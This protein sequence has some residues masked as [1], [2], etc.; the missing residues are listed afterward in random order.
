MKRPRQR[1]R[2]LRTPDGIQL[3]W[4]EAGAGR[5]LVKAANWLTH[6][7]YDW[8]SPV[9]RHWMRFFSDHFRY[10]RY[11]ERGCGLTDWDVR[12][13]H[14]DRWV[15][16]LA[17]VIDA[18]GSPQPVTLLGMSQGAAICVAYAARCPDRVARLILYGGYAQGWARRGDPDG[19]REYQAV[20]E[21]ASRGW[22]RENPA[23]RQV[24][25]S[26]FVP[27]GT[28]EQISWFNDLCQKTTSA[29]AV[30]KLLLARAE[31]DV[32]PLLSQVRAPTLVLHA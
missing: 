24:F 15:D 25:T 23:F 20:V 1:I 6:L 21:V 18:V 27:G 22:G 13:L 16:D 30:S 17:A 26:R 32:L 8:E 7:E 10:V 28:D 4:A 9:W 2:Y 29:A 31:I 5:A 3:A 11:D 19:F 12:N 14:L